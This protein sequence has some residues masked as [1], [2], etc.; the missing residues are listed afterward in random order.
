MTRLIGAI[1]AL[2]LLSGCATY[3]KMDDEIAF[4]GQGVLASYDQSI[5]ELTDTNRVKV[6]VNKR[7]MKPVELASSRAKFKDLAD[8]GD[9]TIEELKRKARPSTDVRFEGE[10]RIVQ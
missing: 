2:G 10:L 8:F 4:S 3:F 9:L 6:S 5:G 7:R 1:L